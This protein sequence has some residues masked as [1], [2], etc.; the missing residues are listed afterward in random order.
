[1]ISWFSEFINIAMEG[2]FFGYESSEKERSAKHTLTTNIQ[3]VPEIGKK[4]LGNKTL[5][6]FHRAANNQ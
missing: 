1:M 6:I 4:I 3:Q 5:R 2:I